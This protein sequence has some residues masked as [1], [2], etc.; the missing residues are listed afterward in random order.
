MN[1]QQTSEQR[2]QHPVVFPEVA[3]T[4]S[5]CCNGGMGKGGWARPSEGRL[6]VQSTTAINLIL[7]VR[8][9]TLTLPERLYN[10]LD[11]VGTTEPQLCS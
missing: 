6:L 4:I 11:V 7:D 5:L 8:W 2:H 9:Q 10:G 3:V 1:G